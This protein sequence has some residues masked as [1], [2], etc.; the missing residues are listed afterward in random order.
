MKPRQLYQTFQ[1]EKY[2]R[3]TVNEDWQE[4]DITD[5]FYRVSNDFFSKTTIANRE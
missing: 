1:W 5:F 3:N 4:F 2:I